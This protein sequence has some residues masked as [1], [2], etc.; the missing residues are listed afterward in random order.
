[1]TA[2]EL[3]KALAS[4][5]KE[6]FSSELFK[7]PSGGYAHIQTFRQNLPIRQVEVISDG[8][9]EFTDEESDEDPFPFVIVRLHSGEIASQADPHKVTV[10]LIVGAFDDSLDNDGHDSVMSILDQIQRHYEGNPV[11][12]GRF[13]LDDPFDWYLQEESSYPYFYGSAETH[14]KAPAP[15]REWSKYV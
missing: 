13:I 12:G 8:T 1:M 10:L 9:E 4:E 14:W 15:R 6:L 2:L 5:I 7:S 3:Q 11:A